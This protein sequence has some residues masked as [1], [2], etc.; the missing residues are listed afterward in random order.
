MISLSMLFNKVSGFFGLLAIL[1]GFRLSPLQFSMYIYSVAALVILALL[2]PHIRKQS[3]FECLSLAWLYIFDTILNTAYTTAF[4]ITW[5][6]AVSANKSGSGIPS[7]APGSGTIDDT[8]G[9]TSPKY[10]VSSVEVVATPNSGAGQDAVAFAASGAAATATQTSISHGVGVEETL[11]SLILVF[12]LT[13]IR[14]YFILVVMA[15]ARQVLR[16][17]MYTNSSSKLHIHTADTAG[18]STDENPFAI[19]SPRGEGWRG[20][21]GRV[22]VYVGESYWLGGQADDN[23][24]VKGV[25]GR[26]KTTKPVSG[27]PGTI[28]RER[29]ARS[30]TGPPIPK[31]LNLKVQA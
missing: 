20:K 10:N 28:E 9:F 14:I 16:Q 13:L 19:G 29:R 30:G 6:L 15:Y 2:T 3:P 25:D 7:S 5:T 23:S 24:W 22:M 8:A 26:F 27:P 17:H 11:P 18:E 4:A 12:L 21:L 31:N 1:T